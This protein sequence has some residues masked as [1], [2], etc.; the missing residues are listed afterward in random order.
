[1]T[2]PAPDTADLRAGAALHDG[3]LGLL[4]LVGVWR[5]D[6]RGVVVTVA[7]PVASEAL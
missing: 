3:L 2:G 1:M 6:G 7:L 5:G 4:P